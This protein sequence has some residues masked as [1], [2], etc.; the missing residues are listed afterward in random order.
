M[1]IPLGYA[2]GVLSTWNG[3][4]L[5]SFMGRGLARSRVLGV[6]H[7][8]IHNFSAPSWER[9]YD[10]FAPDPIV[11]NKREKLLSRNES[12]SVSESDVIT[13]YM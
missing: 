3:R 12:E 10:N 5:C 11:V 9:G 2:L 1:C 13:E 4:E 6:F 8:I 7:A